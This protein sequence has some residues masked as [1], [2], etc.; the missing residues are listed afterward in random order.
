VTRPPLHVVTVGEAMGVVTN[1]RPGPLDSARAHTLSFGGAESNVAI[2]LVR[3]GARASWVSL[4]GDDPLGD[5]I[6]RELRAEGVAVHA[7][8]RSDRPTGIMHKHRRTTGMATVSFWRA[9][10]AASRL[11]PTD[12]PDALLATADVVHLTGILAGLGPDSL[13]C[14]QDTAR[15]ARAVGTRVS[16]DVNHR[17]SLWRGRDARAAYRDLAAAADVLFAGEEEA[18]ILV[19][20]GTP[21]ELAERLRALGPR[22]VV[23]KRGAAGAFADDGVDRLDLPAVTVDAVDTV[24]AGDAFV[25]GYL[26]LRSEETTL[27]ER[28]QRAVAAGAFACL[29]SGDWEGA[30]TAAE[31][32]RLG[33]A[34]GV[35]R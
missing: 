23:I 25:A 17:T 5:L 32:A 13:A 14:A 10:S 28:A 20:A 27:A 34:E 33:E 3:L 35:Q 24:G 26:S 6:T 21:G 31:L 11:A 4:L 29:S 8:R 18:A 19:G 15:R 16:F 7:P 22:E 2:G 1:D 9:E 12:V 30:P